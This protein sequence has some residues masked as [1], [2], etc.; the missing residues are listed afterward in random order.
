MASAVSGRNFLPY[1]ARIEYR[2]SCFGVYFQMRDCSTGARR[3][4]LKFDD[5]GPDKIYRP[6]ILTMHRKGS[7]I[8]VID[9]SRDDDGPSREWIP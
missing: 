1:P 7:L 5:C 8:A 2:R 3:A 4:R 6:R 9:S